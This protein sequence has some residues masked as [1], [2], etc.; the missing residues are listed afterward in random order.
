MTSEPMDLR[1]QHSVPC[2]ARVQVIGGAV[3][4][5][6][7]ALV[8]YG[9]ITL[10]LGTVAD[11]GAGAMPKALAILLF[12][13]GGAVLVQG[14]LQ[15][16]E[17]A[18][19]AEFAP[20]PVAIL[21]IAMALFGLFIRGGDF[22]L[23]STPQ[24]GL[25]VVGPLTVFIAGCATPERRVK[26]LLPMSF[27]L[28]AAVLLVFCDLLQV[29]IPIFPGFAQDTIFSSLGVEGAIRALYLAYGGIA[30]A[31][32]VAFFGLRGDRRD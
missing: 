32:Y 31:L 22:T 29:T 6:I 1:S 30:A 9:A 19:R 5:F 25:G 28:T 11:F 27:G 13:A 17:E 8:W 21:V 18:E 20:A 14:V 4:V 3:V 16:P 23:L 15:R 12:V 7:A 2:Y 26:E 24:L 10:N